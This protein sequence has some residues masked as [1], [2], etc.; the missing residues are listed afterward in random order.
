MK[1][2]GPRLACVVGARPNFVKIAPILSGLTEV[3]PEIEP[4]LVHTGQHYDDALSESFFRQLDIPPPD[5]HLEVGS[6]SHGV[7]T[8]R[9]LE[10]YEGWLLG[11]AHRPAATL[12]VGDVNS[13]VACALASVKLGIPVV[14]VEAGLRSFDRRMPEEINRVLTDAISDL[15]LASEPAGV[16]NL[17]R[18]GRP[19]ESVQLVGNVMIDVL[20]SR[21]PA[22]RALRQPQA[23]D[24]VP[25]NYTLWTLHRPSNV[26]DPERLAELTQALVRAGEQQVAVMP[27]HPRTRARL[28]ATGWMP[29]LEAA[30]GVRLVPPL[31]Y[32]EFLALQAEA[33]AVVTD[34]GG[35]QEETTVLGI[36][37]LTLRANTERPV[38]VEVGTNTLVG[39]DV[40][41]LD[42]LLA[43]IRDG[44]YK[45]GR[46]PTLWDGKA[47]IRVAEEVRIFLASRR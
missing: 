27:L 25:R 29:T 7:Q 37:C 5:V 4:V 12:V 45:A 15:L 19:P 40:A 14:H 43:D 44:R 36:P 32:L 23:M 42:A 26:D 3:A 16:T 46:A 34:S 38:T 35:V 41:R 33:A 10:R 47:G 18:E 11:A 17:E 13:T 39:S 8:A 30:A 21:L 22:A 31:G 9:V 1:P 2:Q 20:L 28:E 6:A 24:L